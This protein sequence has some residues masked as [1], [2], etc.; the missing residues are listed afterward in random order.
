MQKE[1]DCDRLSPDCYKMSRS[2]KQIPK[3]NHWRKITMI[4]LIAQHRRKRNY[5][6]RNYY[7]ERFELSG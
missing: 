7:R 4:K 1:G 6:Q 2:D 3:L 5:E